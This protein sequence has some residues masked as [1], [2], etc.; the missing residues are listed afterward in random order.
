PIGTSLAEFIR[1]SGTPPHKQAGQTKVLTKMTANIARKRLQCRSHPQR[2]FPMSSSAAMQLH[3]TG[4]S[5]RLHNEGA[6]KL[7]VC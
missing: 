5:L 6:R 1:A 4:R 7:T 2:S 3:Q